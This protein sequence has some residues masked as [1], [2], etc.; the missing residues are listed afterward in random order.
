MRYELAD[1]RLKHAIED[2]ASL[3]LS[4]SAPVCEIEQGAAS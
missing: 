1:P 2:L 3:T 4:L